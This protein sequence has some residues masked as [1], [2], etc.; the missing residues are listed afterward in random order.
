LGI[1]FRVGPSDLE[2]LSAYISY[3]SAHPS[4]GERPDLGEQEI[5]EFALQI[6]AVIN[7]AEAVGGSRNF[8]NVTYV[9]LA[10]GMGITFE[11]AISVLGSIILPTVCTQ[12]DALVS[13]LISQLTAPSLETAKNASRRQNGLICALLT[14]TTGRVVE[15]YRVDWKGAPTVDVLDS[16]DPLPQSAQLFPYETLKSSNF[17]ELITNLEQQFKWVTAAYENLPEEWSNRIRNAI[18]A[19]S[20]GL[21]IRYQQPTLS[22]V[23]FI[24]ALSPFVKVPKCEGEVTCTKCGNRPPHNLISDA[25]GIS[26]SIAELRGLAG[27]P[28]L[29]SSFAS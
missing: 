7:R 10:Q 27:G 12:T 1:Q 6:M 9:K 21:R 14:L 3:G 15:E 8:N 23:A 28:S 5:A 20:S 29:Q 18:Y 4:A 11:N 13:P 19:Y 17:V 24:A 22:S 16:L 26:E 2:R 25:Y